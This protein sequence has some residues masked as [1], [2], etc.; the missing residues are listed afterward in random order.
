M[1]TAN[2]TFK[3]TSGVS[4]ASFFGI[5]MPIFAF[6]TIFQR[7]SKFYDIGSF[8]VAGDTNSITT[9]VNSCILFGIFVSINAMIFRSSSF[10]KFRKVFTSKF[11]AEQA[12][13]CTTPI[14][15]KT[16]RNEFMFTDTMS[17][18]VRT[19]PFIT[20]AKGSFNSSFFSKIFKVVF[21]PCVMTNKTFKTCF[22]RIDI[23]RRKLMPIFAMTSRSS[24]PS[25]TVFTCSNNFQMIGIHTRSISA[26]MIYLKCFGNWSL[27]RLI[28]K[29]MSHFKFI[30][31]PKSAITDFIFIPIPNP[32]SVSLCYFLKEIF[33]IPLFGKNAFSSIHLGDITHYG[34]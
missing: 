24:N 4:I 3:N 1:L 32:A 2:S 18:K 11:S 13:S 34:I 17:L 20:I 16:T 7:S 27:K 33:E 21:F 6:A 30:V 29:S 23:I 5:L 22:Q 19:A 14:N 9:L 25:P 12:N 26:P 10:G 8:S 28:R 31:D 15:D